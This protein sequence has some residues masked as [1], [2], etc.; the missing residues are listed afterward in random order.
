MDID[1]FL[2][3]RRYCAQTAKLFKRYLKQHK[4]N[5]EVWYSSGEL[6]GNY[7]RDIQ[8]LISGAE[9]AVLFIDPNFTHNFLG[10]EESLECIT[11]KEIV[12][13]IKKKIQDDSFRIITIYVDREDALTPKES[14][15]ISSLLQ[16]ANTIDPV[17]DVKRISQSNAVFFSTLTGDEDELFSSISRNMLSNKYYSEH[18]PYGNFYFGAIQ[19]H[20]DIIIWDSTKHIGVQNIYFENTPRVLPLYGQIE[21]CRSD[22]VYEPQ[23]NTMLSLVG[24]DVVLNDETED[25]ILSVR[26]QKI[27]YCLFYKTLTLWDQ[28]ELN[29]KIAM[30]DWRSDVF[31]IPNAMGMAFM[32]ITSDNKIIFA[33]RS[34]KRRLRPAEFDCSIVEGLK[35]TGVQQKG[36]QYDVNS[37]NYLKNEITRAFREE[38]CIADGELDIYIYGLVLDKKYGQ[39]N[40][41]GTIKTKLS[42]KEISRL[43]SLRDDTYEDNQIEFISLTDIN[44]EP[45]LLELEHWLRISLGEGIWSMALTAIYSS[46]V[47]AGFTDKQIFDMTKKLM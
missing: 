34:E 36:E 14:E 19:T 28:F 7:K 47:C 17:E 15:I 31:Q 12:A 18:I 45:S 33:R 32:V 26:Y 24:T 37:E 44:G 42:S 10:N 43:H 6:Y 38:I 13:I 41:V 1:V 2:C 27:D 21:R 39:W 20:A 9:C 29:K 3:Y 40:I 23:N 35:T 46:L 5:G 16:E 30:F 11:A 25:K 4:F 22:I 8:R